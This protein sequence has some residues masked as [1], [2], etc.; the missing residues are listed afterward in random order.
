MKKIILF[1][2]LLSPSF[3]FAQT[4]INPLLG[5]W[6]VQDVMVLDT[7]THGYTGGEYLL[8]VIQD[9]PGYLSEVI[10]HADGTGSFISP[11]R[12]RILFWEFR[13]F[14]S[15]SSPYHTNL[16]LQVQGLSAYNS[17]FHFKDDSLYLL[18]KWS[19]GNTIGEYILYRLI[20]SVQ[21]VE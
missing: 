18:F 5:R 20:R 16:Y 9:Q 7:A 3:C 6:R 15:Y 10:F 4:E 2:F 19:E 14:N 17:D 8:P 21:Q 11:E 1:A 12:T 13:L